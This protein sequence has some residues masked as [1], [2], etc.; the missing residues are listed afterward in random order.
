MNMKLTE[1]KEP[2]LSNVQKLKYFEKSELYTGAF[3]FG[4]VSRNEHNENSDIDVKVITTRK[5]NC[6]KVSH[7]K[8]NNIKFDISFNTIKEF[9]I[10]TKKEIEDGNR[11]P[12][13][14]ESI[15]IFDK[16]GMLEK[17]K[18]KALKAKPKSLKKSEYDWSKFMLYHS[19]DKA[20][21]NLKSDPA[22][23]NLAMG[24]NINDALKDHYKVN[25][26]WWVSNKRLLKDLH[27]W[28][29]KLEKILRQFS[30][31]ND[32]NKKYKYFVK[33]LD[34]ISTPFGDWRNLEDTNC[35]CKLC[36][37]DLKNILN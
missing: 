24:I 4:S 28:D 1:L 27:E 19:H 29:P 34:Y 36:K 35:N 5:A 3:I 33:A 26:R 31:E 16:E 12:M 15:I 18:K 32:I 9:K 25:K 23:A 6:G 17:I 14:A 21:R 30:L 7:P 37:Q 22:A 2:F 13:I 20:Q 10:G 8:L 11:I